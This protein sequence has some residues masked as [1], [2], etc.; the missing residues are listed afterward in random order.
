MPLTSISD[1]SL[2]ISMVAKMVSAPSEKICS[3]WIV[4]TSISA[5]TAEEDGDDAEAEAEEK[6]KNIN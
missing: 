2:T 1:I 4:C 3:S 5:T 6:K